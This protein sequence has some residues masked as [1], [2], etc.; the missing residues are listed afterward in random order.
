MESK[1]VY[2]TNENDSETLEKVTKITGVGYNT[3]ADMI[4]VECLME[5]LTDMVLEYEKLQEDYEDLTERYQDKYYGQP[6]AYDR[7]IDD[8]LTG[9]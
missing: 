9:E 2:I 7:M 6:D 5:A 8:K 3:P 1:I 4:E